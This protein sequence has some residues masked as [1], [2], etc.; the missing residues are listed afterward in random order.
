MSDTRDTREHAEGDVSEAGPL[1]P[2]LEGLVSRMRSD[3]PSDTQLA[4]LATNV[5]ATIA[6]P[7]TAPVSPSAATSAAAAA[8]AVGASVGTS[9]STIVATGIVAIALAGGSFGLWQLTASST[10][11]GEVP[12]SP[13]SDDADVRSPD[14][15]IAEALS[16]ITTPTV[17]VTSEHVLLERARRI[18]ASDP[19]GALALAEEHARLAPEGVLAPEREVVAIEALRALGRDDEARAR[20][21]AFV[22]RWPGS[23]YLERIDGARE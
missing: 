2:E 10:E 23:P 6:A 13:T 17:S 4:S 8:T 20:R 21:A 9:T 1:P 5:L 19:A 15:S 11:L 18:A 14:A 7:P 12:A 22:S 16:E 3:V